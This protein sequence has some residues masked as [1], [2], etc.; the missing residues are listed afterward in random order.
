M[1]NVGCVKVDSDLSAWILTL[2]SSPPILSA[3]D[4]KPLY[5]FDID[6]FIISIRS[7]EFLRKVQKSIN[8][9][10]KPN[11][12][13]PRN[14]VS[15]AYKRL[16]HPSQILE[17]C[18]LVWMMHSRI[19]TFTRLVSMPLS[20]ILQSIGMESLYLG[21]HKVERAAILLHC[22]QA[23][24]FSMRCHSQ[25]NVGCVRYMWLKI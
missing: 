14:E 4:S 12:G 18:D 22:E 5:T 9:N 11:E 6:R 3:P 1:L 2:S 13:L 23:L 25:P 24:D 20:L 7:E 15:K 17:V 10:P 19:P 16:L 8:L 21:F